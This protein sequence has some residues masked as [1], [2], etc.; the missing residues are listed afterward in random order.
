V[1]TR[2]WILFLCLG[3]AVT[4]G[5]WAAASAQGSVLV[6]DA[7]IVLDLQNQV[8]HLQWR[9]TTDAQPSAQEIA[10][11]LKALDPR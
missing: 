1:S 8:C 10:A 9:G 4:G 2:A 6:S 5:A 3:T 11:A 7:R